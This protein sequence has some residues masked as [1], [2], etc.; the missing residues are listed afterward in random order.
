MII[1]LEHYLLLLGKYENID[2]FQSVMIMIGNSW[3]S[4]G[5]T[6]KVS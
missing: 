5:R 1:G 6:A 4:H 2:D 3:A